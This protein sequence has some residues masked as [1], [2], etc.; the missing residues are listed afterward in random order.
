M[1]ETFINV[2]LPLLRVLILRECDLRSSD[3]QLASDCPHTCLLYTSR[4][5]K[6]NTREIDPYVRRFIEK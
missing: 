1:N 4:K 3:G 2:R 5:R 6:R